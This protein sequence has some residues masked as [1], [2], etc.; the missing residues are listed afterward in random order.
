MMFLARSPQGGALKA[1]PLPAG[2]GFVAHSF[3]TWSMSARDPALSIARRRW[4]SVSHP[5]RAPS[6]AGFSLSDVQMAVSGHERR[7]G[8]PWKMM[9]LVLSP[10]A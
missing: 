5:V 6:V 2:R 4:S 8:C 3:R 7:I 9:T 10:S 1:C